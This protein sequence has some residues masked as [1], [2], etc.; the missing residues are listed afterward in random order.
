MLQP[1]AS[2]RLRKRPRGWGREKEM[3]SLKL[4]EHPRRVKICRRPLGAHGTGGFERGRAS[5]FST[6]VEQ[7]RRGPQVQASRK[8]VPSIVMPAWQRRGCRIRDRGDQPTFRYRARRCWGA[9]DPEKYRLAAAEILRRRATAP[10]TEVVPP[11]QARAAASAGVANTPATL[12][13]VP[14]R[15]R[16]SA[17]SRRRPLRPVRSL[18]AAKLRPVDASKERH[19]RVRQGQRR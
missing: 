3:Q 10:G 16:C 12:L 5:S 9:A 14:R 19:H 18:C 1:A 17:Q 8:I 2:A 11:T 15:W 6:F 4:K 7:V 13:R